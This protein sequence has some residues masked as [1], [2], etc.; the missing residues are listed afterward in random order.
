MQKRN[1]GVMLIL[2]FVTCGIYNVYWMYMAREEFRQYSGQEINPG[3]ELLLNLLCFPFFYYWLFK[4]SS[5]IANVQ[6]AKGR[7]VSD[8][9]V[10]NLLLAIFGLGLVSELIIQSQLNDLE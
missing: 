1:I 7:P 2:S 6:R 4:F 9:A 10:I 8:N 3:L 5:D